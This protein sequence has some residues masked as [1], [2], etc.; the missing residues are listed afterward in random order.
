MAE[1]SWQKCRD[2]PARPQRPVAKLSPDAGRRPSSS[3]L[4]KLYAFSP[5]RCA[6][7]TFSD[8]S[9]EHGDYRCQ[10]FPPLWMGDP[11][12]PQFDVRRN[13]PP[14]PPWD[15][16][17]A[18]RLIKI[19]ENANSWLITLSF[20]CFTQVIFFAGNLKEFLASKNLNSVSCKSTSLH[21][22]PFAV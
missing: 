12:L 17:S 19:R 22:N 13:S 1:R 18:L 9:H 16:S 7:F 10:C 5:R 14:L 11:Q 3:S 6:S 4:G 21:G 2:N 8:V 15:R 20:A